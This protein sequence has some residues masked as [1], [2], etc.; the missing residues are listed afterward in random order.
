MQNKQVL[1]GEVVT[2]SEGIPRAANA[3]VRNTTAPVMREVPQD[4]TGTKVNFSKHGNLFGDQCPYQY[5]F[6]T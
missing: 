5:C 3:N 6:D 2:P 1:R 4:G